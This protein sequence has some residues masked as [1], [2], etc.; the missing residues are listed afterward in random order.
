MFYS[1]E[2]RPYS[3]NK[4]N[5]FSEN[6][7]QLSNIQLVVEYKPKGATLSSPPSTV[8]LGQE[9][10]VTINTL[11]GDYTY[12]VLWKV[13]E[14]EHSIS[15]ANATVTYS[16][17]ANWGSQFP[18]DKQAS[19]TI[20]VITYLSGTETGRNSYKTTFKVPTYTITSGV[21]F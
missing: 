6:Y 21:T 16:P 13:G 18:N 1:E 20:T 9:S 4:Y 17:P 11:G 7:V 19:G 10:S 5:N 12:S 3:S 14:K 8:T 15:S 2:D